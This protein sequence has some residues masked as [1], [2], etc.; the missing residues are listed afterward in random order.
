[1]FTEKR[2]SRGSHSARRQTQPSPYDPDAFKVGWADRRYGEYT[3]VGKHLP[4]I[5]KRNAMRLGF[6]GLIFVGLTAVAVVACAQAVAPEVSS[7]RPAITPAYPSRILRQTTFN[8]PF[9]VDTAGQP[10]EVQLYLSRDRGHTWKLYARQ[11]PSA[12]YFP[13]QATQDGEY[14][15]A[16]LSI[17]ANRSPADI[18]GRQAELHVVIDTVPPEFEFQAAV[19]PSREVQVTWRYSDPTI[20]PASLKIE[21][22]MGREQPWQPVAADQTT[23]SNST[24]SGRLTFRPR[25]AWVELQVRAEISDLAR[26]KAVVNRRLS[27]SVSALPPNNGQ[28][29]WRPIATRSPNQQERP[30][31]LPLTAPDNGNPIGGNPIG[32]NPIGGNPIGRNTASAIDRSANQSYSSEVRDRQYY[33]VGRGTSPTGFGSASAAGVLAARPPSRNLASGI[34]LDPYADARLSATEVPSIDPPTAAPVQSDSTNVAPTT[35]WKSISQSAVGESGFNRT[36]APSEFESNRP[37]NPL[38]PGGD[39]QPQPSQVH[40]LVA[41]QIAPAQQS[42]RPDLDATAPSAIRS[43]SNH[44]SMLQTRMTSA[45]RFEVDYEFDAAAANGVRSVE[46]WGTKD[47]GHTWSRWQIDT[48]RQSPLDV[49][50]DGEGTYGFRIV[51]VGNNGLAGNPPRNGDDADLWVGVDT[52]API[53]EITT[54]TYGEGEHAGQLDIRWTASDASFGERPISILFSDKATGPWTTIVAGIP[55]SGQYFWP[56]DPRVPEHLFL[57]IEARDQAGNQGEYRLPASINLSGFTPKARI[58][59]IRP[60]TSSSRPAPSDLDSSPRATR[61][62]YAYR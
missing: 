27:L 61:N 49:R 30:I 21:Y 52:T 8:I 47:Q 37:R 1:M 43:D 15:F 31:V 29:T 4:A 17:F 46:L 24:A 34:P 19:G 60:L 38:V 5:E 14:W 62:P 9:T 41:Q 44:V 55:N 58:R 40:P 53:V 16:S 13:F 3:I 12:K 57:R 42:T 51:I 11:N 56:I 23:A 54:A 2:Q 26:N 28:Q 39:Y 20:D 45:M 59:G 18:A 22:K 32:G 33:P 6:C 25:N 7:A 48:D 36:A 50:V 10:L 35:E